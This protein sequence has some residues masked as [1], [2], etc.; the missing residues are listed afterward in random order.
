M[1]RRLAAAIALIFLLTAMPLCASA[2]ASSGASF[3][4]HA[5]RPLPGSG[6]EADPFLLG[7]ADDLFLLADAVNSGDGLAGTH[8]ALS[9]DIDLG[10][11][12][13]T[14]IGTDEGRPFEGSFHGCGHVV[15]G[16]RITSGRELSGLF[17]VSTGDIEGVSVENADISGG[18][19]SAAIVGLGAARDCTASGSVRG[20]SRVGGIVGEGSVFDCESSCSVSGSSEVGGVIGRGDAYRC[21]CSSAPVS[22]LGICFG[23]EGQEPVSPDAFA[24]EKY[25]VAEFIRWAL[26]HVDPDSVPTNARL[27]LQSEYCGIQ[28]WKYLYGSIRAQITQSTLN[29]FYNNHYTR[30]MFRDQYSEATSDWSNYSYAT[31][32]QGLLDAWMTYEQGVPTDLNCDM[33]YSYWCTSK[34]EISSIDR[35]WA[36]GEAVFVYSRRLGRMG[37]V[38]WICGFDED[39]EPLVAE[40]KGFFHGVLITPLSEGNWTH[41]GLM[42]VKFHYDSSIAPSGGAAAPEPAEVLADPVPSIEPWD[43]VTADDFAGGSG[44]ASDPYR[45]SNASQLAYLSSAVRSGRSFSGEY[46]ILTADILFNNTAGWESWDLENKP[47]NTW[48]PIGFYYNA[49]TVR[50]FKG[51]FD[52]RGHTVYGL[53]FSNDDYSFCGLFGL[54]GPNPEG[55]IKNVTV[56]RSY[57][58]AVNGVGG[59]VGCMIDYGSVENCRNLGR[60][61]SSAWVGGVVG[62]ADNSSVVTSVA[63]CTN[64]GEVRGSTDVGGII[65]CAHGGCAISGCTSSGTLVK[66]FRRVGGIAGSAVGSRIEYCRTNGPVRGMASVGGVVGELR[67]SE[68]VECCCGSSVTG[69]YSVGGAVGTCTGSNVKNC[70]NTGAVSG[71][72]KVG[73]LIGYA[74]SSYLRYSYNVG[75]VTARR[76]KGGAIGQKTGVSAVGVLVL[77]GCCSGGNTIGTA[78]P[79]SAFLVQSSYTGYDFTGVWVIDPG[80]AYPFAELRRAP[81]TSALIPAVPADPTPSPSPTPSPTPAPTAPPFI[82]ITP[83]PSQSS[84]PLLRGDADGDGDVD[85][86]DALI[87]LRIALGLV[88]PASLPQSSV[89]M[90]GDGAITIQD[91]LAILRIALGL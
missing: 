23:C 64:R 37:H 27:A 10:G 70:F 1:N 18:D 49:S 38:G 35:D 81:Y 78:L 84:A 43:G 73:G 34:G 3:G 20:A 85:A 45:I 19:R 30:Y 7:C 75:S 32:C 24:D 69:C 25:S 40:A 28:P 63:G 52:G 55:C 14:P 66:G 2:R 36:V 31:D 50:P 15:K 17:G 77:S 46:I 22:G 62:Y 26:L 71:L 13:W 5:G 67:S 56:A 59:I 80:T 9:D 11:A 47:A 90:D 74:G 58:E 44:T 12:E 57:M 87:V 54:V 33:N 51:S 6:S 88:D 4:A 79:A 61:N 76:L 29:S 8:F 86:S 89:D 42:T 21:S 83:D 48:E 65:G 82:P 53:Y 72:E 91:A 16:L 41:R 39:G 60:I 68:A